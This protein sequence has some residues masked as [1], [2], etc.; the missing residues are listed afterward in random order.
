MDRDNHGERT[1]IMGAVSPSSTG[2]TAGTLAVADKEIIVIRRSPRKRKP[3]LGLV[4]NIETMNMNVANTGIHTNP[5]SEYNRRANEVVEKEN[6][7]L[8]SQSV[9]VSSIDTSNY[10]G[11]EKVTKYGEGT[12][13]K[14]PSTGSVLSYSSPL[15]TEIDSRSPSRSRKRLSLLLSLRPPPLSTTGKEGNNNTKNKNSR[16]TS[17]SILRRKCTPANEGDI[18]DGTTREVSTV[19]PTSDRHFDALVAFASSSISPTADAC[20]EAMLSSPSSPLGAVVSQEFSSIN[21]NRNR[22][23]GEPLII[24]LETLGKRLK[25]LFPKRFSQFVGR[26]GRRPRNIR[27]RNTAS[28][29]YLS[30]PCILPRLIACYTIYRDHSQQQGHAGVELFANNDESSSNAVDRDRP[31]KR[32]RTVYCADHEEA[33]AVTT[34]TASTGVEIISPIFDLLKKLVDLEWT[35]LVGHEHRDEEEGKL[36]PSPTAA[37]LSANYDLARTLSDSQDDE[38]HFRKRRV[39]FAAFDDTA[40]V[41]APCDVLEGS[42]KPQDNCIKALISVLDVVEKLF[43]RAISSSSFAPSLSE[44]RDCSASNVVRDFIFY[45]DNE[46]IPQCHDTVCV[47][48]LMAIGNQNIPI[49]RIE[50]AAIAYSKDLKSLLHPR[51]KIIKKTV[52]DIVEQRADHDEVIVPISIKTVEE[53]VSTQ[54]L[55]WEYRLGNTSAQLVRY[56]LRTLMNPIPDRS[57]LETKTD[58]WTSRLY[59]FVH[60][61]EPSEEGEFNTEPNVSSDDDDYSCSSSVVTFEDDKLSS[62]LSNALAHLYMYLDFGSMS[63]L[64]RNTSWKTSLL[65]VIPNKNCCATIV[66]K[67]GLGSV[68]YPVYIDEEDWQELEE[69]LLVASDFCA[70]HR[71]ALFI[72]RLLVIVAKK[73]LV[74]HWN[75]TVQAAAKKLMRLTLG[76]IIQPEDVHLVLLGIPLEELL[77]RL[78]QE[79]LPVSRK[80]Y[81][82]VRANLRKTEKKFRF[83]FNTTKRKKMCQPRIG[84][85]EDYWAEWLHPN[86]IFPSIWFRESC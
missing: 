36:I 37:T 67:E 56:W 81:E 51:G 1:L 18:Y 77:D 40:V 52:A 68:Q 85:I 86:T 29:D 22:N 5:K 4:D 13:R 61:T 21:S 63:S 71:R 16:Q 31:T 84:K 75:S 24:D 79:I 45:L 73:N 55:S 39:Q 26:D 65:K 35:V 12:T 42:H 74:D 34:T 66:C 30:P 44:A 43:P 70:F 57:D 76:N 9:S 58:Q 14:Q 80:R 15:K 7:A 28:S 47:E 78:Q 50:K 33:A 19:N 59:D 54:P 82:V 32:F 72:E 3:S 20:A 6:I 25:E 83:G 69:H 2:T 17:S 27:Q 23:S 38:H 10:N 60:L 11:E 48:S 62:L 49:G 53:F 64:V 46:F 41:R 8:S